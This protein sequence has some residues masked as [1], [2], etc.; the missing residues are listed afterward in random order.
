MKGQPPAGTV[1]PR[2]IPLHNSQRGYLL[3]SVVVM[4]FLVA[5]IAMLLNYDSAISANTSSSELEASRADYVAEAAVQHAL[6]RADNNACM[7]NVT[8]PTTTLG[9]DSYAA[10]ISGAAA[11]TFYSL[12]ADQDAWI[13]SDDGDKNNNTDSHH[14]RFEGG[15]I[16]QALYRFDL[17]ALPAGAQI[18]SATAWFFLKTGKSHPEGPITAHRVTGDWAET[19][20]TWDTFGGNFDTSVVGTISAQDQ[21]DVW[22]QINLT[23]QVQA[24]VNGQPN[25]GVLFNSTAENIHTEYISREG[26]AS[27]VPRLDVVV[28]SGP[29]SPVTVLATG[30]LANGVTRTLSRPLTAAYQPPVIHTFSPD[31]AE[32]EDAEIWDQQPNNNYGDSGETWVSSGSN[33]TTRS[34][35]RFNMGAIPS[36]AK[37][38][39]ATLSLERQ[40]GSGADQPVSAHRI[41]NPWSEDSVTWNSRESGTSWD[42]AGGDFDGMPVATTPVGPA[43]QRYEWNITPLAQGWVDGSYS[44]YGVALVAAIDGMPGEQFYTSDQVTHD[45]RPSLSVT[46]ACECGTAC[47]SPQSTGKVLMV[48]NDATSPIAEDTYKKDLIES[49]GYTVTFIQDDDS[50]GQFT[51]DM[52]HNDVIFISETINSTVLDTKLGNPTIGIVNT[53]GWM[54]DELGFESSNSSNWPVGNSVIVT[55]TSH[56]ITAPFAAGSLDIYDMNMGGLGIGGAPAAGAQLLADWSTGA[57][58]VTLD[59][60][61]TT[62]GGTSTAGR[63]VMLPFGRAVYVNWTEVNNNGHL[64]MQRAL[65]WGIGNTGETGGTPLLYVVNDPAKLSAQ[66]TARQTLMEDWGYAVTL[67]DDDAEQVKFDTE[68]AA[69]HVA[70]IPSNIRE[71]KLGTKLSFA[72]IGVINEA[73]ELH[74][75]LGLQNGGSSTFNGSRIDI[76]DNAHYITEVFP[77]GSLTITTSMQS[78]NSSPG[79]LGDA[80]I[81]GNTGDPGLLVIETGSTLEGIGGIAPA[82]RIFLPWGG[83]SFDFNSLNTDGQA[84]M[85]RAIEWAAIPPAAVMSLLFVVSDSAKPTTDEDAK[86]SLIETWN[87]AV[88]MIS[89]DD[90]QAN[91]DTEVVANDVAYISGDVSAPVLGTKLTGASIGIV[92]EQIALH[93]ELG[94]SSDSVSI[95]LFDMIFVYDNTHSITNGF[96]TGW[97]TIATSEQTLNALQGTLAAGLQT[98]TV[99]ITGPSYKDGLSILEAD[100]SLYGGGN[101][102]GRRAQIP[103]GSGS[104]DFSALNDNGKTIMRR[105]IEW[106]A[107][108]GASPMAPIAHWKLDETNGT[109]AVDFVGSND[110]TLMNGPVWVTGKVDGGLSLDGSNDYIDVSSMN[111]MSYDDFTISAWYKSADSSVSDDEY[112]YMHGDGYIDAITFGPTDD[113][114]ESLRLA[115]YIGD[116]TDRHYGMSDIVDQQWHHLV[117][118]RSSGRIRLYVDNVKETDEADAYAGQTIAVNGDGPFIGDYPGGT[119]QVHGVLDD[120]RLYDRGLTD[121]EVSELF[122]L[123]GGGGDGGSGGGSG[124][125]SCDGNFRDNF[126]ARTFNGSNGSLSWASDWVE[127]GESDGATSGGTQV[128]TDLSNYQLRTREGGQG[129]ERE[130]DLSGASSATLNYDYRRRGLDSSS[131]YA[132]IEVSVNGAAGPWTELIRHQGPGRDLSYQ[133]ASH[134]ISSFISDTTRIRFKTSSSMG[135]TDTVWFDNIEIACTP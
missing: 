83:L 15:I 119:E 135:N 54:N 89:D 115:T 53:E 134:D 70:Y 111:P 116:V 110:G 68:A 58:L 39:E 22:V 49:W 43:D 65:Q 46:Y 19:G 82:R 32:S 52:Q 2:T 100:A 7:G 126:D 33:D 106:A 48:V 25:Y 10:T 113:G 36:G 121:S 28:G 45:D 84:I 87:Y 64:I 35:L 130:A 37:I 127:V 34:L 9:Q 21:D 88:K 51:S 109:T 86:K 40:S 102:A 24:W 133:P 11:G 59:T 79:N 55:D 96:S 57:G 103:W 13:R 92:N 125:G 131:D 108:D 129:A 104:F 12:T 71:A 14:I 132:S 77:T 123:G 67:I 42:T 114:G 78:L 75:E 6:W 66:E 27:E 101:A 76:V 124:G 50:H 81:L 90:S 62:A 60:G 95:D 72:A 117:A 16:E 44:N 23:G 61:A 122:A 31:P 112:I 97:L 18:N 128:R 85:Q 107:G 69:N 120:V 93:D 118:V 41:A 8:I 99:W 29:A 91:F 38:L 4:L 73:N 98:L 105:A 30:T 47:M 20:V 80:I 63:R 26:A 94:F 5:S 3:I 17:S 56:Y 1:P 74:Q